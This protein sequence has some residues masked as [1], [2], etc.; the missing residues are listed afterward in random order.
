MKK[1]IRLTES[2]LHRIVRQC[3]NEIGN[4]ADGQDI[5]GRLSAR[6]AYRDKDYDSSNEIYN[7]AWRQNKR[8]IDKDANGDPYKMLGAMAKGR[9]RGTAFD[10]GYDDETDKW[11]KP[12]KKH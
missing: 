11:R 3:I 5:L 9:E 12:Y 8:E 1:V 7:Y 6:K 2:D 10:K 4:T